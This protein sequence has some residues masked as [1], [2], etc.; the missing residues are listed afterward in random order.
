MQK[1]WIA[2][3]LCA[4]FCCMGSAAFAQRFTIRD[5][6]FF[7]M[8]AE[9][10]VQA[11][12]R[13]GIEIN[14]FIHDADAKVY[15]PYDPISV[16]G[17]ALTRLYEVFDGSSRLRRVIYDLAPSPSGYGSRDALS[18]SFAEMDRVLEDRHAPAR[19]ENAQA[20]LSF[21][22]RVYGYEELAPLR[23]WMLIQWLMTYP[24][25]ALSDPVGQ[26]VRILR[27]GDEDILVF[28]QAYFGDALVGH[29]VEY[30]Q[31]DTAFTDE[32]LSAYQ[33]AM[34]DF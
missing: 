20:L 10:A 26:S 12:K 15:G 7:G 11:E 16:G 28:H 3:A 22:A 1:K 19:I 8:S 5:G 31:L 24:L 23:S 33:T 29:M 30:V 21:A 27:Y 4:L 34:S 14:E 2:V 25:D 6:L 32:L 17:Y 18:Q 9:E 13:R